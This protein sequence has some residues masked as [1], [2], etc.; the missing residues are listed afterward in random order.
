MAEADER[1]PKYM[2]PEPENAGTVG[3]AKRAP[4]GSHPR[5]QGQTPVA[6]GPEIQSEVQIQENNWTLKPGQMREPEKRR[7]QPGRRRVN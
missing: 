6:D 2:C 4:R 1:Q 3:C 7:R 5:P